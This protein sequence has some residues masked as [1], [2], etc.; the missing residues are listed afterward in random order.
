MAMSTSPPVSSARRWNRQP[1]RR[2]TRP[3]VTD[4]AKATTP[5]TAAEARIWT[6]IKAIDTPT[7]RASML[8]AMA[9]THSRRAD[10]SGG[11]SSSS[12]QPRRRDSH[13]ILPPMTASRPK[14]HRLDV[15]ADAAAQQPA[16]KGHKKLKRAEP[17]THLNGLPGTEAGDG[18]AAG[19]GYREGVQ[20]QAHGN[21]E[22]LNQTNHLSAKYC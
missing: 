11:A 22:N 6:L 14:V 8:V 18:D 2:P 21:Q 4:R 17:Q 3:P 10:R 1:R 9:S 19:H 7:A 16:Q 5:M 15:L 20:R 13:A 12:P